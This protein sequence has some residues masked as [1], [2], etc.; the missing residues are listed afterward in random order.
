MKR[1][2]AGPRVEIS[3][4]DPSLTGFAGL[5][6]PAELIRRTRLV[7]RLDAAIDAVEP[8]KERHRGVHAGELLV[9]L[10]EMMMVGGDHL[11]HLDVLRKDLAGAELRT[12]AEP[13]APSTAS[14]LLRRLTPGQCGAAIAV[15]AEIGN[16]VDAALGLDPT[17][18]I[19]LDLD[20]TRTEVYGCQ[21]EDA[22]Y[23][24][25]GKRCLGSQVVTWAERLRILAAELLAG[26]ASAKPT[27]RALLRRALDALPAGHGEVRLRGDSDYYFVDLLHACRRD[28]VRFAVS[29]PRS[30]AM[31]RIQE[32]V[33]AT[34]WRAARDMPHAEVAEATYAPEG[35]RHEPL[36]LLVRRVRIRAQDLSL[37]TRSRRRRTVPKIQLLLGLGGALDQVFGYSFILTDLAG[38]AVEIEQW[39]RQRAQI[40]ERIKD[41]KL[42]CG[43]E[44]LPLHTRRANTAWQAA[45]VIAANLM[46]LLSAVV[47]AEREERAVVPPDEAD[48]VNGVVHRPRYRRSATLRRW[49]LVVPGRIVRGG[50]RLRLRLPQGSWWADVIIHAYERL[51]LLPLSS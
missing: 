42:G 38:D 25:E 21:K 9:A 17:A 15:L 12:I 49:M 26:N 41:L 2:A 11:A 13:P 40:E 23:S 33:P 27:A 16:E 8:F 31:W 6:L 3:A 39:Q 35:W 1:T 28:H 29:V 36:R 14:Q 4:D 5:L 30:S 20:A 46:S 18:P 47:V 50:R 10:S 7:E 44:H 48:T 19:T 32:A 43:L 34:A 24:Y 51:R 37:S 45:S 22:A